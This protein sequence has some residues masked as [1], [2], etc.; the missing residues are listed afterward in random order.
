MRYLLVLPWLCLLAACGGGQSGRLDHALGRQLSQQVMRSCEAGM[1]YHKT[2]IDQRKDPPSQEDST[3]APVPKVPFGET[4]NGEDSLNFLLLRDLVY[5]A[6]RYYDDPYLIE[7]LTVSQS[8][9]T[10]IARVMPERAED[11]DLQWQKI[12]YLPGTEQLAFVETRLRK[13]SWLYAMD[14]DIAVQFDSL[15]RYQQHQLD[16]VTQVPLLGRTFRATIEGQ[17]SY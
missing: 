13:S 3:F 12:R 11:V 8:G 7:N 16:V 1:A 9:D 4:A 5:A 14:I 17:G 2:V 15:G 6:E 10:T